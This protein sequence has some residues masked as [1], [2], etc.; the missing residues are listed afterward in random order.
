LRWQKLFF[1][2]AFAV[3]L[4]LQFTALGLPYIK[5]SWGLF[6]T[7]IVGV[8]IL[9]QWV[10]P[11][12]VNSM[13]ELKVVL[14]LRILRLLRIARAVRLMSRF[15]VMWLLIRGLGG[16]M[17]TLA[18]AMVLLIAVIYTF[19]IF[20][21]EILYRSVRSSF[22]HDDVVT[23]DLI[24]EYFGTVPRAMLTLLQLTTED[25]WAVFVRPILLRHWWLIFYFGLF[26][27]VAVLAVMNLVT[28]IIV[29]TSVDA[30]KADREA[31]KKWQASAVRVIL[32]EVEDLITAADT[33][34]SGDLTKEEL[35]DA[36]VNNLDLRRRIDSVCDFSELVEMFDFI[37]SDGDGLLTSEE[38][39]TYFSEFRSD[40]V[41][42]LQIRTLHVLHSIE[43][44]IFALIPQDTSQWRDPAQSAITNSTEGRGTVLRLPAASAMSPPRPANRWPFDTLSRDVG[45]EMDQL[46]LGFEND[47]TSLRGQVTQLV[48]TQD[49]LQQQISN[50]TALFSSRLSRRMGTAE[51][52]ALKRSQ[53]FMG[54]PLP[55]VPIGSPGLPTAVLGNCCGGARAEVAVLKG[56]TEE[57]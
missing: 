25:S 12:F 31:V 37:D 36:Y 11:I 42:A 45:A 33:D 9:A 44:N 41:K 8:G 19:A 54:A 18:W 30:A 22:E 20:G 23:F 6:D 51:A 13:S 28:A 39:S 38:L 40:P 48:A 43:H 49:Q 26:L 14:G 3:E 32:K 15:R 53:G 17:I 29:E 57:V 1:L 55:M 46:K 52:S 16:A 47:L 56:N 4:V 7:T 34:G 2:S 50:L 24:K 5:S 27:G 10:L 21:V 35:L